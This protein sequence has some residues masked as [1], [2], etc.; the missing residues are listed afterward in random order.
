[1]CGEVGVLCVVCCRLC[2]A[3]LNNNLKKCF[4]G[5][6]RQKGGGGGDPKPGRRCGH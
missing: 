5:Q 1:M 2:Y 6:K 3:T 4:K